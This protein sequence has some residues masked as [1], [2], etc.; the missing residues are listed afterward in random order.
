MRARRLSW[1]AAVRL[2]AP[3]PSLIAPAFALCQEAVWFPTA[4]GGRVHADLYGEGERAVL[5]AHGGR[6]D[7]TSWADQAPVIAAAGFRVLAID[8]RGRGESVGGPEWAGSDEGYVT[9]VRAAIDYL[10]ASAA[11]S[12]SIVGASFG[13][14]AAARAAVEAGPGEI[15]ALVLL[16]HSPIER[17]EDLSG[18]KLFITARDDPYADGSPRLADIR[19]QYERAPEPRELVIL[20]GEAHAQ[21]IFDTPQG[22]RLLDEILRFLAGAAESDS[23]RPPDG[24]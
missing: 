17:P 8:F 19:D 6:F 16:A 9:D 10:R 24:R 1:R 15:D 12:V 7:R 13:G 22:G 11:T 21:H 20:D 2:A 4:D 3:I 23:I 18:R 5:L 14:W